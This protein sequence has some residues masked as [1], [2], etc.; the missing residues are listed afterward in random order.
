[1]GR[2][3]RWVAAVPFVVAALIVVA[4]NPAIAV[5]AGDLARVDRALAY[6]AREQQ[7]NGALPAFSPIGSTADAIVSFVAAGIGKRPMRDA[8]DYLRKQTVKGNA[9]TIGLQAKVV[10]AWATAGRDPRDVAGTD[11]VEALETSID[12]DGRYGDA[13]VFDQA[14]VILALVRAGEAVPAAATDWLVAA[15]CTDG[16]WQYDLPAAASD[17]E[18][19]VST[20]DPANDFFESETNATSFVLQALT[21]AGATPTYAHDPFV[22]LREIRDAAYG[23]WGYS[24]SFSTTD[25]NSTALVIQAYAASGRSIPDGAIAALRRLQYPCGA[26]AF[27]R[28]ATGA[29]SGADVGATI[30]AVLGLLRVA[31][32]VPNAQLAPLPTASTCPS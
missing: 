22:F 26:F 1:M 28:D 23:G 25:A 10:T 32:P 3:L 24:W 17:D 14:L 20:V 11:L 29:R 21:A 5:P 4:P 13:A 6:V 7:H 31:H 30:G 15:Q 9:N 19:C 12:D 2:T 18:H 27:T 16:G 8:L